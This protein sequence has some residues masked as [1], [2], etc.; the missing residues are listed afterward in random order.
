M[1]YTIIRGA[2]VAWAS[3]NSAAGLMLGAVD[4]LWTGEVRRERGALEISGPSTRWLM[5]RFPLLKSAVLR[6]FGSSIV[7]CKLVSRSEPRRSAG[8]GAAEGRH[9]H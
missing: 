6:E 1:W 7:C 8:Q 2:K 5:K 4:L 3:P 9:L